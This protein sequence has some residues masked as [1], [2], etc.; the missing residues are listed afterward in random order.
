MEEILNRK[1][2]AIL[3]PDCIQRRLT[4]KVLD[5]LLQAEF[6]IIGMK[7]LLAYIDSDITRFVI[8]QKYFR[9]LV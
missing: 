7:I 4:G 6:K 1:T 3:K 2:L 8:F 9:L 5:H